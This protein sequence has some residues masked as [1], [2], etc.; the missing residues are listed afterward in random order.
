MCAYITCFPDID[1]CM[2][3]NGNCSHVCVNEFPY[4][5]CD[6]P[7]GGQLDPSNLTC[8]FNAD[9]MVIGGEVRCVC[10]SGYRDDS[11]DGVLNCTGKL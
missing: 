1:E 11:S 7:P 3:D 6:C 2:V 10:S 5:H 9:C 4:Y 8:V